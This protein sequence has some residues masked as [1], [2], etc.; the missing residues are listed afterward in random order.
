LGRL[1]SPRSVTACAAAECRARA[2]ATQEALSRWQAVWGPLS[3]DDG[4][5]AYHIFGVQPPA[6][7]QAASWRRSKAEALRGSASVM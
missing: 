1:A 3:A 4:D 6:A 5:A 2:R 7:E